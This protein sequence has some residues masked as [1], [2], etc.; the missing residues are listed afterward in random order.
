MGRH[1]TIHRKSAYSLDADAATFGG[2][3]RELLSA[4]ACKVGKYAAEF[5]HAIRPEG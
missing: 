4:A 5:A 2:V 1:T 3:R